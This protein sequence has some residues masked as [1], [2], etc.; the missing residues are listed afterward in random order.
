ML[1]R[2][3]L[4]RLVTLTKKK[5]KSFIIIIKLLHTAS[6]YSTFR[7]SEFRMDGETGGIFNAFPFHLLEQS[8]GTTFP[9]ALA[10]T[11][12]MIFFLPFAI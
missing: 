6:K 11:R 2:I 9:L 5:K 3:L 1:I 4:K 8:D 12:L 10:T 7:M